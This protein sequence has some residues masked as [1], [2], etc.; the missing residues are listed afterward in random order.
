MR[1][2]KKSNVIQITGIQRAHAC[3]TSSSSK[4]QCRRWQYCLCVCT[5]RCL[6]GNESHKGW[7]HTVHSH[8]T[9]PL[10][11]LSFSSS[12]FVLSLLMPMS[13]NLCSLIYSLLVF[14]TPVYGK[15]K[16]M[17]FWLFLS[18]MC[19]IPSG[20]QWIMRQQNTRILEKK[21]LEN[22]V[23]WQ[24]S[25]VLPWGQAGF[26]TLA[27]AGVDARPIV[28]ETAQGQLLPDRLPLILL[29]LQQEISKIRLPFYDLCHYR[30]S[31]STTR[32]GVR[33]VAIKSTSSRVDGL[34]SMHCKSSPGIY[35]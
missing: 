29:G 5:Y 12:L 1:S 18:F 28:K 4:V 33:L 35:I 13:V 31:T 21:V 20:L 19:R 9:Y 3:R 6:L 11:F 25:Q 10:C 2:N 30:I 24:R 17:F 15:N 26:A 34:L 8:C 16:T 27:A 32:L 23:I 7:P 14:L 22:Q